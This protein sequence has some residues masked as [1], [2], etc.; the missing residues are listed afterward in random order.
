VVGWS[1]TKG[2]TN[3]HAFLWTRGTGMQ[4]LGT[5]GTDVNSLAIG[6]ND[7]GV[8]VGAS[9]DVNFNPR[10]FVSVGQSLGTV[11]K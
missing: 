8:V 9:L 2:D 3:F 1:D 6:I 4:D 11:K 10:A 7:N 5:V